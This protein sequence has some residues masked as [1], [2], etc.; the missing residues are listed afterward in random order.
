M[1]MAGLLTSRSLPY[2][3]WRELVEQQRAE[4][5]A[6][7]GDRAGLDP[8]DAR[9]DLVAQCAGRLLGELPA[10]RRQLRAPVAAAA[11]DVAARSEAQRDLLGLAGAGGEHLGQPPRRH[12][13]LIVIVEQQQR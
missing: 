11:L 1:P 13:L 10:E 2:A 7:L 12:R 8:R 9:G 6:G 5:V 3:G 4:C